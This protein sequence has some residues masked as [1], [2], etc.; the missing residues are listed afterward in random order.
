MNNKLETIS[1]LF[2]GSEIRS[3]WDSEKEEY[4]FSVV[5]VISALTDSN[6]PRNY[7][8]MLKKRMKKEEQSELSTKCVQLKMKSR[9]DGKSYSTDTLDT[10]GI[11]RL[12]E[13]VPSPKAEPF[14]LWLASLGS[15]RIDEVFDPE[16]AINRAVNYY[17]NKGYSDEWIKARLT[18]I[19]DRFKLTDVW[20][21]GGITK[22]MEYAL[23]TNEIY[24]GW[25]GMKASEYK[26]YKG[27]RKESLRDNMTDIEVA[28]TN[29]G[30]IATRDIARQEHPQ[31]LTEN[32]KVAK[33]G[34]GVAKGTRDLY[35]KETNK[36]A[37]SKEN[38]LNYQY[39]D[40]RPKIESTI[41][42]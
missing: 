18:G 25:S 7:W 11:L 20:K 36:S 27:L 26:S 29:I 21:E 4:Y 42:E 39:V 9:K 30:E 2:E 12:I 16:I 17:R 19:V 22:P 5:D 3:I 14:K 40:E 38:A 33:R 10:K 28:L 24:K 35:E 41:N 34:D 15:E 6:N 37:L 8:N 32:L 23:L 13:S 31:G 1:N